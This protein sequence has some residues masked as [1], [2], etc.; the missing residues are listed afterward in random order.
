MKNAFFTLRFH[1]TLLINSSILGFYLIPFF[2]IFCL[3]K[4]NLSI[5]KKGLI[6]NFFIAAFI[7]LIPILIG[8]NYFDFNNGAGGGFLLKVSYLFFKNPLLF[9]LTSLL[10]FFIIVLIVREDKKNAII[11]L[12]LL[13]CFSGYVIYQKNF[14]PMFLFI[15]FLLIN[16]KLT[17]N[18]LKKEKTMILYYVY[19]IL[20]LVSAFFND[21]LQLSSKI[22]T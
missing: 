16:T 7:T 2:L 3:S 13:L 17:S 18:F 12:I 22:L 11:F 8:F 1:N 10:G 14:E 20:Y 9:F 4:N 19:L 6:N 15:L 5:V 21:Y